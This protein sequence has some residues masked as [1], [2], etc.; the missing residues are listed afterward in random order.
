MPLG[1]SRRYGHTEQMEP[2]VVSLLL[3]VASLGAAGAHFGQMFGPIWQRARNAV[4]GAALVPSGTAGLLFTVKLIAQGLPL[5]LVPAFLLAW[6]WFSTFAG[7]AA[8]LGA[9][10]AFYQISE[11]GKIRSPLAPALSAFLSAMT[12][13]ILGL[14]AL[15]LLMLE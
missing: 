11:A 1:S 15:A 13:G 6:L 7:G 3:T 5:G 10:L 8:A 4:I 2:V 14:P 9:S 12:F